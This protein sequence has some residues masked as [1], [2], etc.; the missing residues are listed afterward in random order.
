LGLRRVE[1]RCHPGNTASRKTAEGLGF[2]L[3]GIL[4]WQRVFP[5]GEEGLTLGVGELER[6][7]G[8][9]GEVPGRHTAVYSI[10]WDEWDEKRE[11][12]VKRMERRV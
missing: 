9:S 6:R 3:E 12:V 2:V 7:N 5:G 8:T 10:V 4:R 1:W 11:M